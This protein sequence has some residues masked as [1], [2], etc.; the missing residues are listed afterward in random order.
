MTLTITT[1]DWV[2]DMPR[3]HV[4]DLRI[5]WLLEELGRSYEV[6]TVPLRDKTPEHVARQPFAQVPMIRDGDLSLFESGAILL[7]LAE[8]SAL[9]PEG[10]DRALTVQWLIAALNSI[11]P[12]ALA[13]FVAKF[14]HEDE[15]AA[16]RHEDLLRRRLSQL[17]AA[18]AGRDWLV[19]HGFTVADLLMADILRLPAARGMLDDLHP[20]AAYLERATG[21][22]AFA[23]AL[24]DQMAHWAAADARQ[25]NPA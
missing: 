10:D 17:Q 8:G 20:L 1:Y 7:H 9:M 24:A 23:K 5:R 12:W 13:W 6:D 14:M 22:P 4:R 19:G 16:A 18:L 11:E 21:R 15:A 25:A 3:G 2:P